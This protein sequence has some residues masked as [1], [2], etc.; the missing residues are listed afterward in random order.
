MNEVFEKW[1]NAFCITF[2]LTDHLHI[3]A[4]AYKH[5][6]RYYRGFP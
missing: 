2:P 4:C 6:D 3:S 1:L 5:K